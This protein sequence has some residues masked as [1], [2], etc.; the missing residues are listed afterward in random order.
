VIVRA[1]LWFWDR[2]ADVVIYG[3]AIALAFSAG[4]RLAKWWRVS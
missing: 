3:A 2:A 4:Y 1:R